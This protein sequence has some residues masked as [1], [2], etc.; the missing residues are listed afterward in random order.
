MKQ[1]AP[2]LHAIW[3][4]A[5]QGILNRTPVRKIRLAGWPA[6]EWQ[7]DGLVTL[8]G[9]A[10]HAVAMC[11]F[12]YSEDEDMGIAHANIQLSRSR[13]GCQRQVHGCEES[14]GAA[15]VV[16]WWVE[17]ES[18]GPRFFELGNLISGLEA[19][20]PFQLGSIIHFHLTGR[21]CNML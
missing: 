2:G 6:A 1:I 7:G 14:H 3:R 17:N 19:K 15:Q 9:D 16:A 12:V 10:A 20:R 18:P 4:S 11:A 5:I 13:R 8:P 21:L